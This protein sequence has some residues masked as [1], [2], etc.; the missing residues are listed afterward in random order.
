MK[1]IF[2]A[3]PEGAAAAFNVFSYEDASMVV[4]AAEELNSPVFLM[5]NRSAMKFMDEDMFFAITS[6]LAKKASVPVAVHLDHSVSYDDV[7]RAIDAGFT[8]V[9]FDGSSLPFDENAE[10]TRAIVKYAKNRGV[11]VEAEIGHVSY[12]DS[13]EDTETIYTS[14]DDAKLF[15]E[16][17]GADAIAVSVG[18]VH[19]MV[20]QGAKID[21]ELL[22][23]IKGTVDTP[24]V[25]HGSSGAADGDLKRLSECGARK[26]NIGTALRLAFGNTLR[27]E[28]ETRPEV[29]DRLELFKEPM[30]AV[31]EKA[32]EKILLL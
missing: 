4:K 14:P 17:T 26:I 23:R 18:T 5:A 31:Y 8:S 20:T 13:A 30:R 15:A 16:A 24:L 7:I 32:K 9:M 22:K 10:I 21:F 29:F 12:S 28:I 25:I 11:T 6:V 19:R 2:E 27:S 3:K 1:E